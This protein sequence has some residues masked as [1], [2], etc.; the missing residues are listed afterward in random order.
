[1]MTSLVDVNL[2]TEARDLVY[3]GFLCLASTMILV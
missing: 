1:V 3:A 2:T